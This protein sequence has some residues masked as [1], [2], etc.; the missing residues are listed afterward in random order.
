MFEVADKSAKSPKIQ[1]NSSQPSL[2]SAFITLMSTL[3]LTDL[4]AQ[5]E[6][7]FN[8]TT[9]IH[10]PSVAQFEIAWKTVD[11]AW[12]KQYGDTTGKKDGKITKTYRCRLTF[13]HEQKPKRPRQDDD[14]ENE[15]KASRIKGHRV[16]ILSAEIQVI[17]APNGTVMVRPKKN[18]V[19]THC[20]GIDNVTSF[21]I[22]RVT[23][24]PF[25]TPSLPPATTTLYGT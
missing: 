5:R 22:L 3:S 16:G 4:Q 17:I 14:A 11:N 7:L 19:G 15:P 25:T 23:L 18:C 9:V 12:V 1:G 10:F 21:A 24:L 13:S 20:H 8:V 6:S 2:S